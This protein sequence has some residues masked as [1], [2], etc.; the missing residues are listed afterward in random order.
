MKETT[1]KTENKTAVTELPLE[2]LVSFAEHP[3]RPY[4]N[5]QLWEL[6]ASIEENGVLMP[7]L[8]RPAKDGQRFEI[9]SGH[10]R[11]S[12]A[13]RAGLK[14]IPATVREMDDD[15]ATLAMVESNLRQREQLLPSEKAFAYK[16]KMEA[17]KRQGARSDLTCD[18]LDHKS[19]KGKARDIVGATLGESGPQVQ[20]FIRLTNLITPL[21]NMVDEKRMAM[22]PAVELSYLP[23]D[24]QELLLDVMTAADC[25]PSLSQAIRLRKLSEAGQ[26]DPDRLDEIIDEEKPN[27]REKVTFRL[28]DLVPYFPESSVE[29]IRDIIMKLI[30]RE[31]KRRRKERSDDR[32]R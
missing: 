22:G 16:M 30:E 28:E 19:G 2:L 13:R 1:N 24:D 26:F 3:F 27:Q 32:D 12:A 25:T 6:V 7:I 14:T 17:I 9:I 18:Q 10:N 15:A 4:T 20:R 21:L 29:E 23:Q 8:V 5:E 11:V 31:V